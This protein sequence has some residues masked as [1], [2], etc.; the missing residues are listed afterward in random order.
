MHS[1]VWT[2]NILFTRD[3]ENMVYIGKLIDFDLTASIG[4]VYP[5]NYNGSCAKRHKGAKSGK[6]RLISMI[7]IHFC[8][9]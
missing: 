8:T 2:P 9:F 4:T 5:S 7:G 6:P 3:N 1:D